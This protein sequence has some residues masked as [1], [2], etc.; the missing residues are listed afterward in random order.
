MG[1]RFA[2]RQPFVD[3]RVAEMLLDP[4]LGDVGRLGNGTSAVLVCQ[5]ND[6]IPLLADMRL[7]TRSIAVGCMAARFARIKCGTLLHCDDCVLR[8]APLADC[9]PNSFVLRRNGSLR[10]RKYLKIHIDYN[11]VR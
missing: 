2:L 11:C 10:A 1:F 6:V 9:K 8:L 3:G 7:Y 4:S 5:Q